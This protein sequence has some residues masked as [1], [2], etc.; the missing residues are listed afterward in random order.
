M[1]DCGRLAAGGQG[2]GWRI[3]NRGKIENLK[4]NV[5]GAVDRIYRMLN[6]EDQQDISERPFT[7]LVKGLSD[8]NPFRRSCLP[9]RSF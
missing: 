3:E 2:V 1:T 4:L 7:N 8:V 9:R 6:P 5:N